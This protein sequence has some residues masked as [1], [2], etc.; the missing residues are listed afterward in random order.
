METKKEY[1]QSFSINQSAKHKS[2]NSQGQNLRLIP[3]TVLTKK[4]WPPLALHVV[5]RSRQL[6]SFKGYTTKSRS[7]FNATWIRLAFFVLELSSSFIIYFEK[8][9][10]A[11]ARGKFS[12]KKTFGRPFTSF[13]SS[14]YSSSP[15]V[16]SWRCYVS[17][18]PRYK[19]ETDKAILQLVSLFSLCFFRDIQISCWF[20][21][22]LSRRIPTNACL[23]LDNYLSISLSLVAI[24]F[25]LDTKGGGR[26]KKSRKGLSICKS[27]VSRHVWE[28]R[29]QSLFT[30][31]DRHH[32]FYTGQYRQRTLTVL[33]DNWRSLFS[34]WKNFDNLT[35]Q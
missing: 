23:L 7:L 35:I 17:N 8:E 16:R 22:L 14:T 19:L 12:F 6:L 9:T 32:T 25:V 30:S 2:D 31:C 11:S 18:G 28:A 27:I 26:K 1:V 20:S 10:I 15:F 3:Q 29:S 34:S 33:D 4:N 5:S 24:D 13:Q 21:F